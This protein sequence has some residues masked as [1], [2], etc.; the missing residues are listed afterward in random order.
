MR[1]KR[2]SGDSKGM[3][4]GRRNGENVEITEIKCI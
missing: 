4:K 2:Q 3:I 1:E